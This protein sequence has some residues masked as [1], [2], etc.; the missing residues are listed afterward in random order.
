[1]FTALSI[2]AVAT[3]AWLAVYVN[4]NNKPRRP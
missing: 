2:Y 1:M 4:N 3:T